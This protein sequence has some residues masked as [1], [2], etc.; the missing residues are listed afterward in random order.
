VLM[1]LPFGVS[2]FIALT[3]PEYLST[4]TETPA[5]FL[6]LGVCGLLLTGGAFWL[7]KT[8]SIRF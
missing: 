2:G 4:F 1:V 6:M 5:G 8:V 7:K 3:N